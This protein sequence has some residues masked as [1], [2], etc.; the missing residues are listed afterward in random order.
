MSLRRRLR[1]LEALRPAGLPT[2]WLV[3]VDDEGRVLDDGTAA[4]RPWIGK[5]LSA[6]P[7][8]GKL[9]VGIDPLVV[10]GQRSEPSGLRSPEAP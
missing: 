1:R 9:I 2:L 7:S 10:V 6:V 5:P 8:I 4:V 3:C